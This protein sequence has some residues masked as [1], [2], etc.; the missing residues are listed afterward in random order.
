[1]LLSVWIVLALIVFAVGCGAKAVRYL[2]MPMHVRW[3]LYPVAHEKGRASY[4]GSY[5]EEVDWWTKPREVDKLAEV[6]TI[7]EEVFTLRQVHER[8][9][10]LWLPSL[11]FH[12]GL[13][14]LCTLGLALAAGAVAIRVGV[15][16]GP[17]AGGWL[18]SLLG[19]AGI[20][21]GTLGA[22]LLLRRRLG[23]AELR[24]ASTPADLLHL[25]LLLAV[26]L[27]SAACW[28]AADRDYRTASAFLAALL[29]GPAL[30]VVP[31]LF[32]AQV[33]LLGLFLA[34][35]PFSHMTHF[36]TKYFTWH[37]VR[38]DDAPNLNGEFDARAGKL[39]VRPIGWSAPHIGGGDGRTWADVVTR[40]ERP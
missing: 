6:R 9:R 2:R 3:E 22:A 7:L 12:Y 24:N 10:P 29:G 5:F 35:L 34:Y 30:A 39:L 32:V 14:A 8:N 17:L 13:Y 26:F 16:A 31:L 18:L 33:A 1:M 11:L 38:W 23:D 15:G 37:S 28:L 20:V 4:G 21:A 40:K 25:A 19:A 36:F 27:A